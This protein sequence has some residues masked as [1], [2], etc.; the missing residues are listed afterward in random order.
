MAGIYRR[1][2]EAGYAVPK[3]LLPW[4]DGTILSTILGRMLAGGDFASVLLVGNK[5]DTGFRPEVEAI[6]RALGLPRDALILIGDTAGQAETARLGI[7]E[8]DRRSTPKDRRIVFH[9]I[10]TVLI[11]RDYRAVAE[12]LARDDGFIDTFRADSPAY[13]YVRV[14]GD[15]MVSDIAE[16]V[17]ISPHATTG[18]YGFAS[19]DAYCAAYAGCTW[20]GGE[21]YVSSLY[22]AMIS[23]GARLRAWGGGPRARTIVLGTPAEYEVARGG[24]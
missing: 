16:K 12:I 24:P 2:R 4:E 13:S 15:G 8:V 20:A 1:F 3:F 21:R 9:N 7:E 19:M 11:D 17:A 6:L 14:D 22:R 10:D 5:R 23:S 18:L